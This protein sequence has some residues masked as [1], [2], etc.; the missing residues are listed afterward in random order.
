MQLVWDQTGE[1]FYQSGVD[2]GVL[3][4]HDGTVAVWNGIT[5]VE[6]S[7][8]TEVKSFHL[9][10]VK[11]LETVIPGDFEGKLKAITYPEEF[12]S[13]Q[14][15]VE[16]SPGLTYYDQPSKSFNLSYQTTIG[17]DLDADHGYV[18]HILYNV[19]ANPDAVTR[20]T[21]KESAAPVEFGWNLSGV[22]PTRG[23]YG[24][25]PTV[26]VSIDS[27][28]TPPDILK[29]ITDTLYG[30]S[31]S[32]ASLPSLDDLAE[33]FGYVGALVIID[34]GDGSWSAIDQSDNYIVMLDNTTF[35]IVN[36]DTVIIDEDT[37]T[38]ASTNVG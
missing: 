3:Y 33:Y 38:I 37:Y 10:G 12:D 7:S 18:I 9:D 25:R 15:Q 2:H 24:T 30:T 35:E 36:A 17:T 29:I 27:N 34:H 11:Y 16:V 5:D 31:L 22:P 21:L 26:H 23:F 1:R 6:E 32:N 19:V 4:L 28:D 13:V 20:D 14:G 8:T